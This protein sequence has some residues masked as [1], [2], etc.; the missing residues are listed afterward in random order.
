METMGAKEEMK[1]KIAKTLS[2]NKV[3]MLISFSSGLGRE[4][5]R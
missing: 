2:E 5:F 1:G 4:V 3:V